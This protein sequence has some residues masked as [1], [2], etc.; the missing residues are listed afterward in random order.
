MA[1]AGA[2]AARA[3]ASSTMVSAGTSQMPSAHAGV[4]SATWAANSGKPTVNCSM[5]SWSYKSFVT[6]TLAMPS[7][8]AMSVPGLMGTQSVAKMPV[9][10]KR[11]STMTTRAPLSAAPARLFTDEGRMP[12][13]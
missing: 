7:R 10:F 1:Q 9:L 8:R 5:N 11:G 3:S 4:Y 13:P 12:S 6:S 2:A